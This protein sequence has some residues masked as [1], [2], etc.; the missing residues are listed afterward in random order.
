MKRIVLLVGLVLFVLVAHAT[1]G[2]NALWYLAD[3]LRRTT[4]GAPPPIALTASL[5]AHAGKYF[6]AFHL[7]NISKQPLRLYPY[8]FPWGNPHSLRLAAITTDGVRLPNIYPIADPPVEAEVVVPPGGSREGD[9]DL[10]WCLE[11]DKAPKDKD[12]LVLWVYRV[13]EGHGSRQPVCSGVVVI[14]QQK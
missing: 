13:P 10:S 2:T 1:D 12:L 3:G 11:Y 5:K 14:P 6:L 4:N 8:E 7:V 9:Y